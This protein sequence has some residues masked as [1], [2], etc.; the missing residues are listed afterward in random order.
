M[1][2]ILYKKSC[3]NGAVQ[4]HVEPHLIILIEIKNDAKSEKYC[5]KNK[6][7]KDST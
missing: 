6:L 2:N 7:R 4:I 5:I 3:L 1:R